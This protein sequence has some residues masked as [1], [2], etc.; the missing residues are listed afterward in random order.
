MRLVERAATKGNRSQ[1]IAAAIRH[2]VRAKGRT[3][4]RE[5]LAED[6]ARR[7]DRDRKLAEE[8]FLLDEEAWRRS[9]T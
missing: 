3:R 2:Y 7:G 8:W 9:E 1:F 5:Q 6:A 4:L